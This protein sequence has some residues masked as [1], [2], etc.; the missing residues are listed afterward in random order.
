MSDHEA[1]GNE[2]IFIS[3]VCAAF[4][5]RKML[6]KCW[7]GVR[8]SLNKTFPECQSIII[9]LF[10]DGDERSSS[11]PNLQLFSISDLFRCPQIWS[12]VSV[13]LVAAKTHG[14]CHNRLPCLAVGAGSSCGLAGV[15]DVFL[16]STGA[17][18]HR[19]GGPVRPRVPAAGVRAH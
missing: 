3:Y 17:E 19:A 10:L 9:S 18:R 4:R 16:V 6:G 13:F 15:P 14:Y 5:S 7:V 8:L 2:Q 12:A 11:P 1:N